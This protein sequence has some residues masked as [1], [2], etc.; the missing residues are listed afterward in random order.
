VSFINANIPLIE[1]YIRREFLFNGEEQNE[2]FEEVI[3]FGVTSLR[4]RTLMFNVMTKGGGHFCRMPIHAFCHTK[5][6]PKQTL[7]D[8]VTW[9]NFSY[10]IGVIRYDYLADCKAKVFLRDNKPYLGDYLFTVDYA[11]P[12]KNNLDFDYSEDPDDHKSANLIK[13]DN[14]NFAIMPNNR[15][16]WSDTSF[17]EPYKEI[18]KWKANTKIWEIPKN[19]WKA[20]GDYFYEIE[21]GNND[22]KG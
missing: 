13:L 19:G 16:T 18:P 2:R 4:F 20:E 17:I 3:I 5:N 10:D 11:H 22:S 15:I 1:C 14:G 7:K 6:A 21:E 8:L 9:N 12:Q